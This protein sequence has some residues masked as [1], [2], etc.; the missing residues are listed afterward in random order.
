VKFRSYNTEF[1]IAGSLLVNI[2]NDVVIDR[3]SNGVTRDYSKPLDLE[4]IVQ[5]NIE[6]PCIFGDRSNILRSLEN[7]SG[8]VKL[9]LFILEEKGINSDPSR[10]ADLHVD[11]FYQYDESFS[12]LNKDNPLYRTYNLNKRR[13]LPVTIDYELTMIAKYR[14]D[15]DQ[16]CTNWMVHMRPDIYV[17]WWHP[18]NKTS[19]LESEI[20]WKQSINKE[21]NTD[22]DYQKR[23]QW[24]A[25]TSF[26]FKT[27]V[28]PGLN[29]TETRPN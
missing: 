11:V 27:W 23:F 29:G 18:R 13:G 3:R 25:S 9:P 17:R 1:L 24:K 2:F 8:A 20:L 16:M 26:S 5:K 21:S 22:Y 7:E 19:P 4:K 28:F 15:L 6:V 14:E 10:N 12:N